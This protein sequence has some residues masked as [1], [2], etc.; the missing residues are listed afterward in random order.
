MGVQ[1]MKIP[2][3]FTDASNSMKNLI[4]EFRKQLALVKPGTE[5]FK[6]LE[7][8][9]KTMEKLQARTETKINMGSGTKRD[10]DNITSSLDGLDAMA[11]KVQKDFQML[12]NAS[13]TVSE[14]AFGDLGRKLLD[15]NAELSKTRTQL[16]NL[17]KM[18]I[19]E[20][21]PGNL[22]VEKYGNKTAD[23]A[24]KQ[25]AADLANTTSKWELA[26]QAAEEY[27][28]KMEEIKSLK[29]DSQALAIGKIT[30]AS[31]SNKDGSASGVDYRT[32]LRDYLQNN[33]V[34]Q[35]KSGNMAFSSGKSREAASQFLASMGMDPDTL[36]QLMSGNLRQSWE[37]ISQELSSGNMNV[38]NF[39]KGFF[40][41]ARDINSVGINEAQQ[42]VA[43]KAV[44]PDM[45]KQLS[46]MDAEIA[47]RQ[48]EIER[49][50][51]AANQ[52]T[53][54]LKAA[55]I[56]TLTA[57]E[58]TL[59][60]QVAQLQ[61][62]VGDQGRAQMTAAPSAM[63][64]YHAAS[65]ASQQAAQA[66]QEGEQFQ[67]QLKATVSHWMGVSQ[68]VNT[69]K[70]GIRAAYNDIKS[71]DATMSNMAVV[72][73]LS[74]SDLWGRIDEYMSVAQQY[75]VTTQG[76]YEVMQLYAQQG[77]L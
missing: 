38:K 10:F 69:V 15:V 52:I 50:K 4:S 54:G 6:G 73:D 12:G 66:A 34:A 32:R 9:I 72:T 58:A 17:K 31:G 24:Q 61:Q 27:R 56:D 40:E 33:F 19:S 70:Q 65:E 44:L 71:L 16:N 49:L 18:K 20:L 28:T 35:N 26:T 41:N 22:A 42:N 57:D 47:K 60:G 46:T 37:R 67:N 76:V 14:Q 64:D 13:F 48:A 51:E 7:N 68:I 63:P 5:A 39:K 1:V 29:V 23:A 74:I 36:T 45:E 55:G 62:Q 25:I 3:A 43:A 30:D 2:V 75:G 21:M 59:T 77:Q 11:S 53:Q 8:Q